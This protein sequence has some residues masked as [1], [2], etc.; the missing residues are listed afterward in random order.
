[1]R[2]IAPIISILIMVIM[3]WRLNVIYNI[4]E[5]WP[6]ILAAYQG[7]PLWALLLMCLSIV[8]FIAAIIIYIIFR[9]KISANKG[10]DE[11]KRQFLLLNSIAFSLFLTSLVI[12]SGLY[13]GVLVGSSPQNII[14]AFV[15]T[16]GLCFMLF[17]LFSRLKTARLNAL[18]SL[19]LN[20]LIKAAIPMMIICLIILG[21]VNGLYSPDSEFLQNAEGNLSMAGDKAGELFTDV[22]F[23]ITKIVYD[24]GNN[25]PHFMLILC[26]AAI[27]FI[28]LWELHKALFGE[29]YDYDINEEEADAQ[30]FIDN[31]KE[32]KKENKDVKT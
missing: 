26:L 14:I 8:F 17:Q 31:V 19:P 27:V 6:E 23:K 24:L 13:E 2:I 30:Y 22:S 3:C 12:G 15:L 7:L 4:K 1:M 16:F 28:I 25:R 29:E 11:K 9:R 20:I 10:P 18:C 5:V 32:D 21:A